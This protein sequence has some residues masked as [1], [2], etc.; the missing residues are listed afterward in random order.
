MYWSNCFQA[1]DNMKNEKGTG[2]LSAYRK[3]ERQQGN[4]AQLCCGGS[5]WC[6][7]LEMAE[8]HGSGQ[9]KGES[10]KEKGTPEACVKDPHVS[11][12]LNWLYMHRERAP[13]AHQIATI[14]HWV[15]HRI[16]KANQ[17]WER[18]CAGRGREIQNS[19]LSWVLG[20]CQ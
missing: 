2:Q 16:L 19:F 4:T 14:M 3:L 1:W 11:V 10:C 13:E 7:A 9:W 6:E 5:E 15:Q 8:N 18:G 17:C 12:P 20:A